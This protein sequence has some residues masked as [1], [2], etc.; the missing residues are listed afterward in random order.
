[1]ARTDVSFLNNSLRLAG[2]LYTPDTPATGP[3]PAIVVGHPT[4]GVKEQTAGLYAAR[5]TA[6]GYI[7]L[8]FDAAYQGESEGEPRGLED[9]VQRADDFR[10]AVAYLASRDDVD[11]ERIGAVGICGSGGYVPFAAQTEHLIKAVAT[12]SGA[13]VPSFFRDADPEGFQRLV[14]QSGRLRAEELKGKPVVYAGAVPTEVD[15]TTPAP[16]REF[17]DYYKTSRAGH[18]RA[19]GQWALRSA[20][21]LDQFDAFADVAKIAPRPLVMIVGSEAFTLHYS[22]DAVA[23]AGDTAELYVIEGATHVDLYDRDPYVAEAVAK[24]TDFFGKHL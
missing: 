3:R 17:F 5:L 9:P 13:D 12:V 4:T 20:Q 6:Q 11:A 22:R 19:T 23:A 16:V 18:E 7:T 24:L 8:T 1:M 10:A 14:E 2:H 15:D 21:L